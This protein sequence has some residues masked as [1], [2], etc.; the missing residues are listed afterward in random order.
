M[1]SRRCVLK[2]AFAGALSG[3]WPRLAGAAVPLR[4]G[5]LRFGSFSWAL[6]VIRRHSFDV[7]AGIALDIRQYA[8]SPAAQVALQAGEVDLILQDWLWVARQRASGAD[9]SFIPFSSALGAV[10]VPQNSSIRLLPDLAGQ[11]LGVAGSALDKSWL[12]LRA[13]AERQY[14]LDLARVTRPNFGAPALLGEE[15][16]S[17]R[18]DAALTFWPFAARAEASG[19]RSVLTMATAVA[20]LGIAPDVPF[21]GYVFS[22][23]WASGHR[24]LLDGLIAGMAKGQA[25]LATSDAEWETIAPL[26]GAASADELIHLRDAYRAGIPRLSPQET[27]QAAAALFQVLAATGGPALVGEAKTLAPGTF[28]QTGLS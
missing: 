4:I 2:T 11:R 8:G 26:T 6:D 22:A 9:W 14:H 15:L 20:G 18:L 19:M 25:L 27:E 5:V 10:I 23:R 28:W 13:Y 21:V 1:P 17:G 24:A 3:A 16:R 7:A 12:I